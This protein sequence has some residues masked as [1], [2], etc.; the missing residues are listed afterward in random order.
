MNFHH[1][2]QVYA[3]ACLPCTWC[4]LPTLLYPPSR[5]KSFFQWDQYLHY[6]DDLTVVMCKPHSAS[7]HVFFLAQ[8]FLFLKSIITSCFVCSCFCF[9][10]SSSTLSP[11][12]LNIPQFP[13]E[14]CPVLVVD[15]ALRNFAPA[16]CWAQAEQSSGK[17]FL[18]ILDVPFVSLLS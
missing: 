16:V 14:W 5:V 9:I 3:S 11:S 13:Q 7:R 6:L 2:K 17:F 12:F 1:G 10:Q 18:N 4:F 8:L 15:S